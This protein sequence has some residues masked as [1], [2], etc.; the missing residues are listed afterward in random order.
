MGQGR[1]G[2]GQRWVGR[3][4]RAWL[5]SEGA[6]TI[7]AAP[8]L[9]APVAPRTTGRPI[10]M[11]L[12]AAVAVHGRTAVAVHWRRTAKLLVVR[13]AAVHG[14]RW[15]VHPVVAVVAVV[16]PIRL[17]HLAWR[18][19]RV[20]DAHFQVAPGHLDLEHSEGRVLVEDVA[21]QRS[22]GAGC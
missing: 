8:L 4:E 20:A 7:V 22:E 17:L 15:H 9:R 21:I 14:R 18:L 11:H 16:H 19:A 12:R 6:R 5:L 3:R 10:A 1:D 2:T 13:R